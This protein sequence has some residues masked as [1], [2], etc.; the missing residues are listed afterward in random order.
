[1]GP[2]AY[3]AGTKEEA[4]DWIGDRTWEYYEP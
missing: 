4:L 1:M 3:S 2:Y